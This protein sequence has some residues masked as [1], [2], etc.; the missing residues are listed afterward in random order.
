MT[1]KMI[2]TDNEPQPLSNHV[3]LA[4]PL[5]VYW[6]VVEVNEGDKTKPRRKN[7]HHPI[8]IV[9][10]ENLGTD[11]TLLKLKDRAAGFGL[12]LT[13]SIDSESD[14]NLVTKDILDVDLKDLVP[15]ELV[16][17]TNVE[18]ALITYTTPNIIPLMGQQPSK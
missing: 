4:S 16:V 1:W 17:D 2:L 13:Y 5:Q 3:Q 9:L 12:K 14:G 8:R 10:R 18:L 15:H 7:S 6:D 11:C